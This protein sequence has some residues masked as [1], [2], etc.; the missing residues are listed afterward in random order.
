MPPWQLGPSQVGDSGGPAAGPLR[1]RLIPPVP[2]FSE[3]AQQSQ[4]EVPPWSQ[5]TESGLA[6]SA[7]RPREAGL[8]LAGEPMDV[9]EGDAEGGD[10]GEGAGPGPGSGGPGGGGANED[11][12]M[13]GEGAPR[14]LGVSPVAGEGRTRWSFFM[15]CPQG[16]EDN[17]TVGADGPSK[18]PRRL[19][20]A[21]NQSRASRYLQLEKSCTDVG[22]LAP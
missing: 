7:M 18:C 9:G 14:V 5:R 8:P 12:D 11:V 13:E 4:R 16:Q 1:Q 2:R 21:A 10:G 20:H 6:A 3:A 15:R 22:P 19:P 17:K